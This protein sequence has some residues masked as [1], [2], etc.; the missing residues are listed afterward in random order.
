MPEP[1]LLDP[2]IARALSHSLRRSVLGLLMER[3]EAS[4]NEMATELGASLGTVSYH[5]QILRELE[6]IELVRTEPR[7]GAIEHYY[8]ASIDPY[9]DDAQWESLPTV[10][11]RQLAGQTLGEL[12]QAMGRAVPVGGFDRKGAHV[13]RVPLRLDADGWNELSD[14]LITTLRE[15]HEIQRR[16]DERGNDV[17]RSQLGVVHFALAD[18]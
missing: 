13:D 10:V 16:S 9:L 3:T 17:S 11:R 18:D 8:R 12:M 2:R 6:C 4:P 5:V 7:R 15:V 1:Q 14:L